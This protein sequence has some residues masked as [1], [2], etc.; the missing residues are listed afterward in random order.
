[1]DAEERTR[2]MGI[3][4]LAPTGQRRSPGPDPEGP[5]SWACDAGSDEELEASRADVDLQVAVRA[6]MHLV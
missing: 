1:M 6:S 3:E 2:R 4:R 5:A